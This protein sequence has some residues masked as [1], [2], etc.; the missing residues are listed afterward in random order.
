ME[1]LGE[2][3]SDAEPTCADWGN[4]ITRLSMAFLASALFM[5]CALRVACYWLSL[6]SGSRPPL[7]IE[8]RDLLRCMS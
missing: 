1:E 4:Y 7:V 5:Y 3:L 6:Q 8:Q 2:G